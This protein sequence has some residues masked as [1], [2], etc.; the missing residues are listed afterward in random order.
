MKTKTITKA[1]PIPPRYTVLIPTL[2]RSNQEIFTEFIRSW[3]NH[4]QIYEVIIQDNTG[5][6]DYYAQNKVRIIPGKP[7]NFVNASWNELI[8]HVTTG[9]YI[10]ANDDIA[11][12]VGQYLDTLNQINLAENGAVGIDLESINTG[13]TVVD[14]SEAVSYGW[15]TLIAGHRSN[16][17]A[18]PEA[19][20]IYYGDNWIHS[21][22]GKAL[23]IY[24]LTYYTDMS[25]TSNDPAFDKIK[26]LD[27]KRWKKLVAA[28]NNR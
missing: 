19:I 10:L 14:Y 12:D 3:E 4:D 28:M 25:S 5:Q 13:S 6:L 26:A 18:I 23:R 7:T 16:W 20:R 27:T 2:W 24:G 22:S 17:I 1:E 11:V 9:N 8:S 21:T 15:G